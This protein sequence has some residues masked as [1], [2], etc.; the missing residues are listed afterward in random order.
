MRI[1]AYSIAGMGHG[2]PL[3]TTGVNSRGIPGPFFLEAGISSTS[4]M[5]RF[6][7]LDTAEA[8]ERQTAARAATEHMP[9]AP[10]IPALADRND[11][12]T[13]N[14]A[15]YN[16]DGPRDRPSAFDPNAVIA[17]A[18]KAAGLP[19]PEPGQPGSRTVNPGGIIAAA[20]KAAGRT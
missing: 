1:E 18:F 19:T 10:S 3:A 7:G 15:L 5:A 14:I 16:G 17:A 2:V 13:D 4:A 8:R 12:P 11:A 6:W 9:P 20:L